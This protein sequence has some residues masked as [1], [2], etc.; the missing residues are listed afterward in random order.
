MKVSINEAIFGIP[1]IRKRFCLMDFWQ[2][3]WNYL[4]KCFVMAVVE[5]PPPQLSSLLDGS[6]VQ[7]NLYNTWHA[8]VNQTKG[9]QTC[10]WRFKY[11]LMVDLEFV[12]STL[13]VA[14]KWEVHLGHISRIQ[15]II[16]DASLTFALGLAQGT[17]FLV[18]CQ[19]VPVKV[20]IVFKR[21]LV[22]YLVL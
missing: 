8:K 9:Y 14:G 15:C 6:Q 13:N 19:V 5:I 20:G 17:Q 21:K 1:L 10:L 3:S 2:V 22:T 11:P 18:W 12:H 7:V 4:G 16:K